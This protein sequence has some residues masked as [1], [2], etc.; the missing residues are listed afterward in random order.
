VKRFHLNEFQPPFPPDLDRQELPY[1]TYLRLP[2]PPLTSPGIV[3]DFND[4]RTLQCA[5]Q[6]LVAQREALSSL[7]EYHRAW[8]S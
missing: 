8:L 7:A 2:R 3:L 5:C 6:S 1:S 4:G